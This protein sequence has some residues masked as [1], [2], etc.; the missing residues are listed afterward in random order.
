DRARTLL[1]KDVYDYYA[2]GAGEEWTLA[3]NRRAFERW[4]V[5]PK[6]LVGV[7][8]LDTSTEVLGRRI[9]FPLMIAPMA[10]QREAHPEGEIATARAADRAGTLMALSSTAQS[11]IEEIGKA[12][13]APQWYQ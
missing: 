9:S 2:G 12:C 7:G 8:D 4:V 1:P 5:R 11:S 10:A 13:E 6:V 3:E